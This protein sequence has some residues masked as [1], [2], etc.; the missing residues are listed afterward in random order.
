MAASRS[1]VLGRAR[2]QPERPQSRSALVRLQL[3]SR[4]AYSLAC[5]STQYFLSISALKVVRGAGASPLLTFPALVGGSEL[6]V[7]QSGLAV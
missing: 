4:G 1:C 7:E 6:N 2:C 5:S 3:S